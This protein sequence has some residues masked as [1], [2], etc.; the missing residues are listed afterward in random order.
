MARRQLRN[1]GAAGLRARPR[2]HGHVRLLRRPRTT[3]SRSRPS[4]ARSTSASRSSTRPTCTARSRNEQLVGT[5]HP[6]T[7]ATR[8]SI[9]TKFG[10]VRG[11]DGAFLG[12][13]GTPEYVRKACDAVL[14]RLGVDVDRPLL[15]APRRSRRRRSRRPSARWRELVQAGKVRYLGL[16]E[17]APATIRRAHARP[18]DRRAADRVLALDAATPRTRSCRPCRELGIGFVAYSPLGRGFLTGRFRTH[19]RP[20]RRR[21]PPQLARASRAR[22]SRRTSTLVE[23]VEEHRA[24]EGCT[25]VA[26]RPRLGARRR[27]TTSCRSPARSAC[28][29][30]RRTS[31][32]CDVQLTP[33]DLRRI[34]EVAPKGVAAGTRYPEQGMKTVNG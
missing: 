32:R 24:R 27:A 1:A 29:T 23:R 11:E 17:A 16:S 30:S 28:S 8:S 33:D 31:G 21:L 20:R 15:P 25:P 5:R 19:R 12:V 4:I 2:L 13:N 26:A 3:P 6:R 10:N 14:Q 22:T 34:D 18:P 9:A 7:G